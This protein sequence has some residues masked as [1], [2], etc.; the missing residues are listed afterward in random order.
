[1][2]RLPAGITRLFEQILSRIEKSPDAEAYLAILATICIARKGLSIK[3]LADILDMRRRRV[4]TLLEALETVLIDRQGEYSIFHLQ[5][6]Q[7]LTDS[8][9][10]PEDIANV[11]RRLIA[12]CQ[13]WQEKRLAYGYD[14]LTSHHFALAD[15]QS[16]FQLIDSDYLKEKA[17]YCQSR[18]SCLEDLALAFEAALAARVPHLIL[19]YSLAYN[20]M[21]QVI[22]R[23][24]SSG[25]FVVQ[26]LEGNLETSVREVLSVHDYK[27]RSLALIAL[28]E[29]CLRSDRSEKARELLQEVFAQKILVVDEQSLHWLSQFVGEFLIPF[30]QGLALRLLQML[31]SASPDTAEHQDAHR[32]NLEQIINVLVAF[33]PK[34]ANPEATLMVAFAVSDAF[35][36]LDPAPE[37]WPPPSPTPV[38]RPFLSEGQLQGEIIR[39]LVAYN[40]EKAESLASEVRHP[41]YRV[42][43]YAII[44]H[45]WHGQSDYEKA[46]HYQLQAQEIA[47][48]LPLA[49]QPWAYFQIL[50][51]STEENWPKISALQDQCLQT[52]AAMAGQ[53]QKDYLLFC[54][55]PQMAPARL[56][57]AGQWL[58]QI[59]D[60][61][62]QTRTRAR[63]GTRLCLFGDSQAGRDYLCQAIQDIEKIGVAQYRTYVVKE[64]A[65]ALA[66]DFQEELVP[67]TL[68]LIRGM[69]QP[70]AQARALIF[71]ADAVESKS[72]ATADAIWQEG[73]DT[74]SGLSRAWE[75]QDAFWLLAKMLTASSKETWRQFMPV[76]FPELHLCYHRAVALIHNSFARQCPPR[77]LLENSYQGRRLSPA[78][79]VILYSWLAAELESCG[80][81][82]SARNAIAAVATSEGLLGDEKDRT[83]ALENLAW[84]LAAISPDL[85]IFKVMQIENAFSKALTMLR[86]LPRLGPITLRQI[87]ELLDNLA[88]DFE[89]LELML[90]QIYG[91]LAGFI[92]N[93]FGEID[94]DDLYRKLMAHLDASPDYSK[95]MGIISVAQNL[96]PDQEARAL[97]LIRKVEQWMQETDLAESDWRR[98]G[99]Y[100]DRVWANLAEVYVH[101]D[102]QRAVVIGANVEAAFDVYNLLAW[103]APT[104]EK[105]LF[106]SK[107]LS[108]LETIPD[109]PNRSMLLAMAACQY[110]PEH[111]DEAIKLRNRAALEAERASELLE[112]AKILFR[113]VLTTRSIDEQW[114]QKRFDEGLNHLRQHRF[115]NPEATDR[116]LVEMLELFQENPAPWS[117]QATQKWADRIITLLG[118]IIDPELRAEAIAKLLHFLTPADIQTYGGDL[119]RAARANE[120]ALA[121]TCSFVLRHFSAASWPEELEK[122]LQLVE[123]HI[124]K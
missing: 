114:A 104:Q 43:A 94:G 111:R 105:P 27:I 118:F 10:E 4:K 21:H 75:R 64:I 112:R 91:K 53:V 37:N 35:I 54:L 68:K 66:V 92:L 51:A 72:P 40:P 123:A 11:H 61:A 124:G 103:H 41:V 74:A 8:V 45:W 16:L 100:R 48:N 83:P 63:I 22:S 24:V 120:I 3:E 19:R 67:A 14:F 7:Y 65:A 29:I 20:S 99:I 6:Q 80:N 2:S 102:R 18:E 78:S 95:A 76:V 31:R 97:A 117:M 119:L 39:K 12:Y 58:K 30:D 13:P 62:I 52:H 90:P 42:L 49:L 59:K 47:G 17:E 122:I 9:L 55:L 25:E 121:K 107:M 57:L 98:I 109:Y 38:T 26:A 50:H 28:A 84:N 87:H 69:E 70:H 82:T 73:V 32:R 116:M 5:F 81:A 89:T 71:L 88:G 106:L 44:A 34:T 33:A 15:Y 79:R 113:V 60:P 86:I 36:Q 101:I 96:L 77:L 1:M 23:S 115:Y 93:R 56:D 85:A 110:Y 108:F 46:A